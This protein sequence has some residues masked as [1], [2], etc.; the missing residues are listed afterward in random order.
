MDEPIKMGT[1]PVC[2]GTSRM[3]CPSES[4]RQYGIKNGWYGYLAEDDCIDC[5]NCGAQYQFGGFGHAVAGQV[6]L[7][8]DNG[9]PCV[10]EYVGV[11]KGRCYWG[12]TCKHCG[13]YHTIDSGD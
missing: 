8:E 11:Q 1:C 12:Y 10:H 4:T 9:E 5:T 13:D 7:R 3:P 6:R 2:N